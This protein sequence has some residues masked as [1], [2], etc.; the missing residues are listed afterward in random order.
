MQEVLVDRREFVLEDLVQVRN[1]VGVA[2][3]DDLQVAGQGRG[4]A[5]QVTKPEAR[6][7]ES[8][9]CREP[10]GRRARRRRSRWPRRCGT[11]AART[12]A[13]LPRWPAQALFGDAVADADVHGWTLGRILAPAGS[14][15]KS[16]A[17]RYMP[18]NQ[19]RL[20]AGHATAARAGRRWHHWLPR[21]RDVFTGPSPQPPTTSSRRARADGPGL[22]SAEPRRRLGGR[23][24]LIGS[25]WRWHWSW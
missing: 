10:G 14:N 16:F 2:L 8:R 6:G 17:F 22:A 23:W 24:R 7:P 12:S 18:S 25:G 5:P 1:D 20:A 4:R 11:A 19:T 3:H 21:R 13:R 9:V 15:C